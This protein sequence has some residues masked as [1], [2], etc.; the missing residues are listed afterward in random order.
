M[1]KNDKTNIDCQNERKVKE[2]DNGKP[3]WV[4]LKRI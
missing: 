3:G 4:K 2:G 1:T